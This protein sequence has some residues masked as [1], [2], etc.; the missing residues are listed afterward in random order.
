MKKWLDID[1]YYRI[2]SLERGEMALNH[3]ELMCVYFGFVASNTKMNQQFVNESLKMTSDML[4]I[5]EEDYTKLETDAL[6]GL[7]QVNEMMGRMIK[8][9]KAG[10]NPF[11]KFGGDQ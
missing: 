4:G 6:D 2:G 10:G 11:D 5:K 9:Y 3:R 7:K 1:G 8:R